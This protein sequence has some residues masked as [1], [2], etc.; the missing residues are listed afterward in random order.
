MLGTNFWKILQTTFNEESENFL[1][2]DTIYVF[3]KLL[4]TCVKIFQ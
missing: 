1:E 4:K 3:K 2:V